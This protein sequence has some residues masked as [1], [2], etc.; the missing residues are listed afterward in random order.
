MNEVAEIQSS[1]IELGTETCHAE[2]YT[3]PLLFADNNANN[4][5]TTHNKSRNWHTCLIL[6]YNLVPNSSL[7][8][9]SSASKSIRDASYLYKNFSWFQKLPFMKRWIDL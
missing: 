4:M 5:L 8:E 2:S 3:P 1:K 7:I 6:D 9:V